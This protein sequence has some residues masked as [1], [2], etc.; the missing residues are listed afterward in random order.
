MEWKMEIPSDLR[1]DLFHANRILAREGVVDA[2]G[3]V[4]LRDPKQP[5]TYLLARSISPGIVT[6]DDIQRFTLDSR[7]VDPAAP[8]SYSERVIHGAIYQ[9]RPDVHAVCHFHAGPILPFCLT[10][11]PLT[12]VT[13]VGATMGAHVPKWSAQAELGDTNLL[14]STDK[15][16]RSLAR[17][18][19]EHWA[20]LMA[21]HGAVVAGRSL[22]ETLF[23]AIH[24][25]SDAKAQLD[26]RPFGSITPL[27]ANEIAAAGA[28]NLSA[29]VLQRAWT[30]WLQR[31]GLD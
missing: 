10:D 23:R 9:A 18:L 22:R 12:P 7:P 14:V 29:P 13:H 26:A 28:V 17:A 11:S 2:L 5:D 4:S 19:G 30:Y 1:R 16:S 25:C 3:H 20:V 8:K 24:M 21:N 27:T 15:Q 6:E 31:A